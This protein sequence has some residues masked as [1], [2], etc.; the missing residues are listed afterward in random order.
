MI[1][2]IF[3]HTDF[4]VIDKPESMSFHSEQGAGLIAQLEAQLQAETEH[5]VQLFA[6]HRLDKMTSGL[7]LV[8]L[9]KKAANYFQTQFSE[10]KINKLYLAVAGNKP[11]KKQG[12]IKGDMQPARRGSWKMTPSQNNPA[13]TRFKSFALRAGERLYLLKPLTGRT[14]QL[15]VALKSLSV[16]IFGDRRYANLEQAKLE[17]RGYLHAYA[18]AFDY[19]NE[20]FDFRSVPKQGERFLTTEF[21]QWLNSQQDVWSLFD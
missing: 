12:W 14:H 7:L 13:L 3:R 15:R 11:K 9:N 8:A 17:Q 21:K 1:E 19:A 2:I 5:D 4:L 6:V 16:P 10:R 20:H 18:L